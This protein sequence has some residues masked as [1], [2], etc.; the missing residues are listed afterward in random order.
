MTQTLSTKVL[1]IGAGTGPN[2]HSPLIPAKAG[3]QDF[4]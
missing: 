1:I 2:T 3:T 4:G